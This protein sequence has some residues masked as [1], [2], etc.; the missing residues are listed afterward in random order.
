MEK[1][2]VC[3]LF[4][5]PGAG[6]STGA[7]FI[8]S[9]LK[10]L[11]V[12]CE[13]VSEF[14]KAKV[15]EDNTTALS[16]QCYIFG[17]QSYMMSRCSNKVDVIITDSPLPLCIMYNEINPSGQLPEC[18][19]QTVM[20]VFNSYDNYNV[21]LMRTKT[22]NPVGR[23]QTE[24]ESNALGEPIRKLLVTR[25]IPYETHRGEEAGY[26]SIVCNILRMLKYKE[27]EDGQE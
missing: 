7:A 19:N 5:V 2:I 16:N 6:K 1:T 18:F 17:K 21:L 24:E 10:M 14:A 23:T 11:G 15:W 20:E 9:Q 3:N 4:G 13:L 22:Y 12:N 27:K 8:F 25:H 26:K